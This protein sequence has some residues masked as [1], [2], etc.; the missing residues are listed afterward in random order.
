[1]ERTP[2]SYGAGPDVT[3][4]EARARLEHAATATSRPWTADRRVHGLAMAGFGGILGAYVALSRATNATGWETPVQVVFILTLGGLA[5]WQT[6]AGRVVPRGV[7]H[8]MWAGLAGTSV[9]ALG[10]RIAHSTHWARS[11][12]DPTSEPWWVLAAAAVIVALPALVA[13]LVIIRRGTR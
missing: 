2:D 13:G 6:R 3:P 4:R 5:A 9:L 10:T 8:I 1:M 12:T 11:P 7:R